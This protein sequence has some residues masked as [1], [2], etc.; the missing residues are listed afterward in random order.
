MSDSRYP[1]IEAVRAGAMTVFINHLLQSTDINQQRAALYEFFLTFK[2]TADY[3]NIN[4]ADYVFSIIDYL[5]PSDVDTLSKLQSTLNELQKH[6][7]I[8]DYDM[9]MFTHIQG[10]VNDKLDHL[11]DPVSENE[12]NTINADEKLNVNRFIEQYNNPPTQAAIQGRVNIVKLIDQSIDYARTINATTELGALTKTRSQ[13]LNIKKQPRD[14]LASL[15]EVQ[16]SNTTDQTLRQKI[17]QIIR[18][19]I[20]F[21]TGNDHPDNVVPVNMRLVSNPQLFSIPGNTPPL[22]PTNHKPKA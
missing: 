5:L 12:A 2:L 19:I 16:G 6:I 14:I 15:N 18:T 20:A 10:I 7:G 3:A 9:M 11:I 22:P 1:F 17:S 8:E 4:G 21:F 13:L